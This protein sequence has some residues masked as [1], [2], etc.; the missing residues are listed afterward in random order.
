MKDN[1]E[2]L[3]EKLMQS[4]Y[5]EKDLEEVLFES[6]VS[7]NG[8]GNVDENWFKTKAKKMSEKELEEIKNYKKMQRGNG[9]YRNKTVKVM[10]TE[11]ELSLFKDKLIKEDVTA[12]KKLHDFI[13]DYIRR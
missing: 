4:E 3:I 8:T 7:V 13:I 1:L 12:Q 10:L 11:N 5:D 2:T 6:N 9:R